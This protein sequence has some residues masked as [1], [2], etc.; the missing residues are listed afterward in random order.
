MPIFLLA[1]AAAAPAP[2]LSGFPTVTGNDTLRPNLRLILQEKGLRL[3]SEEIVPPINKLLQSLASSGKLF[4]ADQ[5][6]GTDDSL[7]WSRY[8]RTYVVTCASILCPLR[9]VMLPTSPHT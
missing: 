9:S 1:L 4:I 2:T 3:I 7:L 5:L 8:L 6:A